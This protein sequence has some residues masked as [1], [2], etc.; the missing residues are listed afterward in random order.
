MTDQPCPFCEI[1]AGRAPAQIVR[2][3][4]DAL[5]LVPLRPVVDGHTLVV[6]KVHVTDFVVDPVVSA[7]TMCRAAELGAGLGPYNLITS[8]GREAGQKIEHLL[9][10]LVPR[11]KLDGVPLSQSMDSY[12]PVCFQPRV[13][14]ERGDLN[15]CG[16][17][18]CS[19]ELRARKLRGNVYGD[20]GG[21]PEPSEEIRYNSAHHRAR[22]QL[23]G[24]G[25]AEADG[26]CS[27]R[28]EAALR[29]DLPMDLLRTTEAGVAY[30]SGLDATIGYRNLCRSH[31][32]R[33]GQLMSALR[34]HPEL[35]A[36]RTAEWV[37]KS[38]GECESGCGVCSALDAYDA[39]VSALTEAIETEGDGLALP[40]Y[41]GRGRKRVH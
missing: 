2:E 11:E 15:T 36:A 32:A 16:D 28:L 30:Y 24:Q 35:Q 27:G 29:P 5:A 19:Y 14:R 18:V 39:A 37:R 23:R 21:G 8:R 25:C 38:H 17:P 13:R 22:K 4:P 33:E 10:E 41:S 1:V 9:V 20:T 34:R 31:H 12:C 6:P 7:A 26:T 40:W 3:W